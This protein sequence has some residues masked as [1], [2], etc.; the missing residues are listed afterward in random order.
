MSGKK[1][2]WESTTILS[3]GVIILATVANAF[4]FNVTDADQKQIVDLAYQIII[5]AAGLGAVVGRI[6]ASKRIG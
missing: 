4:G 6:R 1:A 3:G 2:W 5:G